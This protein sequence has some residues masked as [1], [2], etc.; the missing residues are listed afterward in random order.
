[1]A[2]LETMAQHPPDEC[3]AEW[4][5]LM[6]ELG[7]AP[8]YFLAI[9]EAVRQGRWRAARDPKAYLKTVAK[10]EAAEMELLAEGDARLVFPS[11]IKD[12]DS[13]KLSQEERLGYMQHELDANS[14]NSVRSC[15]C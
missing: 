2:N 7:L 11:E 12:G 13:G 1:M 4:E 15:A 5:W 6:K 10:R 9:Y 14:D 8:E 3:N